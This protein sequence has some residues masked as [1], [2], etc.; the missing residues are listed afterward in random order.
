MPTPAQIEWRKLWLF[1]SQKEMECFERLAISFRWG[2]GAVQQARGAGLV[3]CV[4]APGPG[5]PPHQ[6]VVAQTAQPDRAHFAYRQWLTWR[7][8]RH[9]DRPLGCRAAVQRVQVPLSTQLVLLSATSNTAPSPSPPPQAEE[10]RVGGRRARGPHQ[11]RGGHAAVVQEAVQVGVVAY[12][13]Y[14]KGKHG[15]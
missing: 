2:R 12:L 9:T 1:K 13:L 10:A 8:L 6:A 3:L 5:R 14:S 7:C 4:C 11:L 15:W